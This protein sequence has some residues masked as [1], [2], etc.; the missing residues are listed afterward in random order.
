MRRASGWFVLRARDFG[1]S[2]ALS[3]L[4]VA[5]DRA[6]RGNSGRLDTGLH[7]LGGISVGVSAGCIYMRTGQPAGGSRR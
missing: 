5:I 2:V 7:G 1:A 4:L 6:S 3:A